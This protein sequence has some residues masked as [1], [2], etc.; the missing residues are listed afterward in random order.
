[1]TEVACACCGEVP[2]QGFVRLGCHPDIAICDSCLDWLN[3][4]RDERQDARATITNTDPTFRVADVTRAAA[5][6]KRLGF[7]IEYHDESYAFA[8]RDELTIHLTLDSNPGGS[9]IYLHVDDA[10]Q[11]ADEWRTAGAEVSEV[12]DTDYGKHEGRHSDPDGNLI[13]FGSPVGICN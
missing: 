6:Y 13:R 5:H 2:E 1:M 4:K 12:T 3:M 7:G 11:L 8:L 9:S 10:D